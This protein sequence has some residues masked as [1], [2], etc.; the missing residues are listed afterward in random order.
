MR[1]C[2]GRGCV[3]L[4]CGGSGWHSVGCRP[5]LFSEHFLAQPGGLAGL[6]LLLHLC[7]CSRSDQFRDAHVTWSGCRNT[8]ERGTFPP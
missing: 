7:L 2:L 5:Y 3:E 4:G 1:R 8:Q 6:T